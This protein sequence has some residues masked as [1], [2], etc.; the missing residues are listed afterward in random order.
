MADLREF[1]DGTVESFRSRRYLSVLESRLPELSGTEYWREMQTDARH[2]QPGPRN[3][4]AP[5]MSREM[6]HIL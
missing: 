1:V 5:Y 6:K 4:R 2:Y 3:S